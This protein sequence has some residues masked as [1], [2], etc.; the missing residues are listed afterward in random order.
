MR[1]LI[2]F[3]AIAPLAL[4]AACGSEAPADEAAT[5]EVA[6]APTEPAMPT[7]PA[8]SLDTVDYKGT[9]TL[10]R[11]NGS[12]ATVTLD[13]EDTSYTYVAMNGDETDG[14]Y[15]RVDGNRIMVEDFDGEPGYFAV[16]DGAIY[17]LPDADTS[18][19]DV[20]I[21]NMYRREDGPGA[22]ESADAADK[23]TD[24]PA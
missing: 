16:A 9:Y 3:G 1:H 12:K 22:V 15:S 7:V 20:I 19:D 8:D 23:P 5:E 14:S 18:V 2:A 21:S 11:I 4:L 24:K 13:P 17:Y 6:A 10:T